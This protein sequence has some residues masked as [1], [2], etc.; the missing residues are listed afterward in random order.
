MPG[1]G[2]AGNGASVCRARAA[3]RF[4][5]APREHAT[6]WPRPQ[7]RTGRCCRASCRPIHLALV[8]YERP[9]DHRPA[10]TPTRERARVGTHQGRAYRIARS[11]SL[12]PRH[13][14]EHGPVLYCNK[15]LY[16]I[17]LGTGHRFTQRR[18]DRYAD[19]PTCAALWPSPHPGPGGA[20]RL[21]QGCC[22]M[23][24][25]PSITAWVRPFPFCERQAEYRTC[26]PAPAR[27]GMARYTPPPAARP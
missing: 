5:L 25:G 17:M 1:R 16:H 9:P 13:D 8:H 11:G 23:V 3:A 24:I 6:T 22:C 19:R 14:K 27:H 7:Q 10:C 20:A 4:A 12:R 18:R 2:G 26:L 21:A 15:L